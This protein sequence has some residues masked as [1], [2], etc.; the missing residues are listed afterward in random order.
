M[1]FCTA[2]EFYS[3]NQVD[4]SCMQRTKNEFRQNKCKCM[5]NISTWGPERPTKG[6]P[7]EYNQK[8]PKN[9]TCFIK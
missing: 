7:I 8:R 2:Y 6:F 4:Y 1:P 3:E 9:I 5:L